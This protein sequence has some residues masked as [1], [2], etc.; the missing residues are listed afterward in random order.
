MFGRDAG[1]AV[2][3]GQLDAAVLAARTEPNRPARRRVPQRV[4]GKILHGLF[5][6]QR[7]AHHA[8]V[9]FMRIDDDLD[10]LLLRRPG[11]TLRDTL[12]DLV[13]V[14]V[15]LLEGNAAGLEPRQVEQILDEA[16]DALAFF[17][18]HLDRALPFLRRRDELGQ[19]E[20][21]GVAANRGERRHQ[22]VRH[23]GKQLATGAIGFDELRLTR[24]EIGG[25]AIERIG[26]RGHFIAAD[27]RGAGGEIAFTKPVRR[28]FEGAQARL[29]RPEDDERRDRRAGDQQEQHAKRERR[30]DGFG[31][32]LKS[33]Q[34]RHPDNGDHRVFMTNRRHHRATAR[35]A[36]HARHGAGR[37]A[38]IRG[39]AAETAIARP[40][41]LTITG[42]TRTSLA[43]AAITA[44]TKWSREPHPA[45]H[46]GAFGRYRGAVRK[47]DR[48]R[49]MQF[50]HAL[51]RV[52]AQ[53]EFRIALER[54]F[55][56]RRDELGEVAAHALG[57]AAFGLAG[58]PN[59]QRDLQRERDGEEQNETE[60]DPPVEAARKRSFG[61]RFPVPGSR[62]VRHQR[63]CSRCPRRSERSRGPRD[64]S[65]CGGAIA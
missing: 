13:D 56:L 8:N 64:P 54:S 32:A 11:V 36:E 57:H 58:D 41:A 63:T 42:A 52:R 30:A 65:R 16:L 21:F 18:D 6:A 49:P 38:T 7:I 1:A 9:V 45:R 22:L 47:H 31:E 37:R 10:A 29:R 39:R 26:D 17:L 19:C 61:S 62:F 15:V 23:I 28:V 48:R 12:E 60:T 51:R 27:R 4:G 55:E 35:R 40:I 50:L 34:R 43:R 5:E 53:I 3:D 24:S 44:T 25:H 46:V 20:R 59:E 33:R 2:G 14:D